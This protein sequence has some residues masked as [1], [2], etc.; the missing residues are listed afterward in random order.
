[1]ITRESRNTFLETRY[2]GG[3]MHSSNSNMALNS[4]NANMRLPG[5]NLFDNYK[6]N[7]PNVVSFSS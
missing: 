7:M 5:G 3:L 4:M 6:I 1:L 2:V